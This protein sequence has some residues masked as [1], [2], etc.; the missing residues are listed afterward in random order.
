MTDRSSQHIDRSAAPETVRVTVI[1]ETG[2]TPMSSRKHEVCWDFGVPPREAPFEVVRDLDISVGPGRIVLLHGPSGAGKSS[3]LAALV[4]QVPDAVQ[5]ERMRIASNRSLIDA[6]APRRSSRMAMEI[7][8]A[9]GLGEPRLW[10][11]RFADLS[12]GERF[13]ALLAKAIG[14]AVGR[15]KPRVIICDEFTA[16]LHRRAAKAIAFNLRK[17]TT[18]YGLTLVLASTHEDIIPDLQPDQRIDLG[19]RP[20]SATIKRPQDRAAHAKRKLVIER[21]SVRHYHQFSDMHYRHRDGL[22]FVDKVFLLRESKKGDPLGILV[23]AHAPLELS[24]RNR[25]TDGRFVRN[26]RRLNKELRILR[27]LVMH[28]DVRGCGLGHY[29]VEKTLP[30]VGVR[31]V[32]CLAA[33]GSI[34]PV[35]ER[36]GM[37]KIG[38]CPLPKGRLQLLERMKR[39]G[40]DPFDATFADQIA[41]HAHVRKLVKR[42]INDWVEAQYGEARYQ[43]D[44]KTST[45]LAETFRQCLG[46]PPMYYLWD[47]KGAYPVTH[48]SKAKPEAPSIKRVSEPTATS[49]RGNDEKRRHRPDASGEIRSTRTRKHDPY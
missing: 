39:N 46:K 42:T 48:L 41:Q 40:V 21:G 36:A 27:R 24:L 34:N 3:V 14:G 4:E 16:I 8:T 33:M 26:V 23:F 35:F 49:K 19:E 1:R 25:A 47:R 30:Q 13:R 37:S 17:L 6:I 10:I 29:F 43:V 2:V 12:D 18:R 45:Q 7:L 9:C 22:G 31:F 38:Q 5:V 28:P 15:A 44:K 32:E 11:R 20:P